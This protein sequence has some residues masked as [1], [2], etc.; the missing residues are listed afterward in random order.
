MIGQNFRNPDLIVTRHRGALNWLMGVI[1]CPDVLQADC[2]E[3]SWSRTFVG[4]DGNGFICPAAYDY[5]ASREADSDTMEYLTN[6]GIPVLAEVTADDVRGKHVLGNLPFHLAALC[7][8][9][10]V[11]EFAGVTPRGAEYTAD[12][13]TAAGAR[14]A[15]YAVTPV[16]C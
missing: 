10:T 6:S 14:L 12:D 7:A 16:E 8:S 15:M 11:I 2:G 9:V 1:P 3:W 4:A 13:M 5:A